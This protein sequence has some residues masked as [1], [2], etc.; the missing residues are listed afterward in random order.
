MKKL[1]IFCIL[2]SVCL[3]FLSCG[4]NETPEKENKNKTEAGFVFE[5]KENGIYITGYEGEDM[6]PVIPSDIGGKTVVGIGKSAFESLKLKHVK[7]PDTLKVIEE[8]AFRKC[9]VLE[10]VKIPDS[11]TEIRDG[12]FNFCSELSSAELGSCIEKLGNNVFAV[13]QIKEITIPDSC[14][15]VGDFC[16]YDCG[17]LESVIIGQNV[18]SLGESCFSECVKLV[19]IDFTGKTETLGQYCFA[20]CLSLKKIVLPEEITEYGVG[21]FFGCGFSRFEVGENV[22]HISEDAFGSCKALTDVYLPDTVEKIEKTAFSD[23]NMSSL[24][25]HCSADST[26]EIFADYNGYKVSYEQ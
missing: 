6:S 19:D 2:V 4:K 17:S 9:F 11:C 24:T 21:L 13:T 8:F 10:S 12:A 18:K 5:E 3:L 23:I 25:I 16:F 1:L 26:G 7:L 15:S 14:T 20:N 22:K